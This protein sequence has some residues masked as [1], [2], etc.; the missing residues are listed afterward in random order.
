MMKRK[1]LIALLMVVVMCVV[2]VQPVGAATKY[3][4]TE[5]KLAQSLALFQ[6][7]DLVDPDS[8]KIKHIYKVNYTLNKEQY[9]VY[10]LYD[11]LDSCKTI[12]WEVEYTA[13]NALGGT[14][15]D[16]VY[17][18]STYHSIT[19]VDF[20]E[21]TDKTDYFK[22]NTSKKFVDRIKRLTKKYYNKL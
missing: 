9:K 13:K 10:K 22:R 21:Y 2:M 17:I 14:I 8:F 16:T 19:D 1:N 11:L 6:D 5:K 12:K 4:K 20:D 3:T 18:S 15:K 7:I